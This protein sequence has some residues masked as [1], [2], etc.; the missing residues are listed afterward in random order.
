MKVA[1]TRE[2]TVGRDTLSQDLGPLYRLQG[3]GGL[4]RQHHLEIFCHPTKV[5]IKTSEME[6][7]I[8]FAEC[9]HST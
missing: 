2:G 3:C 7:H 1:N 6:R 4:D 5:L 8:G 9:G